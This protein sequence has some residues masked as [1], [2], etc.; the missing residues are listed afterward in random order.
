MQQRT[1]WPVAWLCDAF[2]V[3]GSGFHLAEPI[4]RSRRDERDWK[5]EQRNA[6]IIDKGVLTL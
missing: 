1:I 4:A 2:G 5:A 3:S 6:G